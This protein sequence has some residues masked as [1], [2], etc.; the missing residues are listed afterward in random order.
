MDGGEPPRHVVEDLEPVLVPPGLLVE[1]GVSEEEPDL[2]ADVIE[3]AQVALGKA[4]AGR[5]PDD[6]EAPD[7]VV[8]DDQRQEE[9]RLMREAPEH[10]V[11]EAWVARNVVRVHGTSLPPERKEEALLFERQRRRG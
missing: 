5:P 3:T 4:P 2:L 8:L 7:H 11:R 9:A 1:P 6:V 10:P